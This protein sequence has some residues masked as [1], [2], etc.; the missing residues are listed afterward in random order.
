VLLYARL[1]ADAKRHDEAAAWLRAVSLRSPASI[2]VWEAIETLSAASGD[3]AWRRHASSRLVELRARLVRRPQKTQPTDDAWF[4]V[5][6]ALVAGDLPLARRQLRRA[7]LDGRWLAARAIAVGRP[8]L[9]KAEA[10]LRVGADPSESDARVALALA[11]DLVG[12]AEHTAAVLAALPRDAGA[13]TDVG[14]TMMGELLARHVGRDVA[15]SWAPPAA[16][17]DVAA[18]DLV[19]RLRERWSTKKGAAP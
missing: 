11:L 12:D 1:L 19:R 14:R 6:E 9:A 16:P 3:G 13:L 7:H 5:D 10:E 8:Q 18:R 17:T 15:S 2:E 4:R